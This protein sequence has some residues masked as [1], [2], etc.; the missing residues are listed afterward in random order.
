M[1]TPG[2]EGERE[3]GWGEG[4]LPE[5]K[6]RG[7]TPGGREGGW[8]VRG[9]HDVLLQVSQSAISGPSH[10]SRAAL[11]ICM[12]HAGSNENKGTASRNRGGPTCCSSGCI[13]V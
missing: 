13:H 11:L 3:G 7:G 2:G 8:K 5:V 6:G 9:T 4:G 12:P 10:S 1:R